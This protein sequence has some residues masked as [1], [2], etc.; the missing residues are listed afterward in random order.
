MMEGE[1]EI[2]MRAGMR[3]GSPRAF[4]PKRDFDLS[5]EG[6]YQRSPQG[7]FRGPDHTMIVEEL[8][9]SSQENHRPL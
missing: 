3:G 7:S 4:W 1:P 9:D 8:S 5:K 2:K 6:S